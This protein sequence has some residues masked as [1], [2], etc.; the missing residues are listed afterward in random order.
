MPGYQQVGG[1]GRGEWNQDISM[2]WLCPKMKHY[3]QLPNPFLREHLHPDVSPDRDSR[4]LRLGGELPE[5]PG[6]TLRAV[7]QAA[8]QGEIDKVRC[9]NAVN[10]RRDTL[11]TTGITKPEN[12]HF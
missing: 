9:T 8:S 2:L 6:R 10:N 12:P 11:E 5:P 7:H 3:L 1:L 4:G